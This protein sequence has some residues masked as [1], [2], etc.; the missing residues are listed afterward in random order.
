MHEL[1]HLLTAALLLVPVG[2]IEFFP[3]VTEHGVKLGSVAI[4]KTD[5]IRRAIIGFAPVLFGT[6][7]IL[8]LLYYLTIPGALFLQNGWVKFVVAFY[9]LFEVGNTMFS[10]QK[11]VEGT[12]E[13]VGVVGIIVVALLFIGIRPPEGIVGFFNSP[14]FIEVCKR[15]SLFLLA[16]L[17]VDVVLSIFTWGLLKKRY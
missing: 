2:H 13:L 1:A 17:G 15:A 11:D 6:A 12:L 3:K 14:T 7:I 10:S 16:P 8:G 5:V 4:A 9:V